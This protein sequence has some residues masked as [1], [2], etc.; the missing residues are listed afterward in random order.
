MLKDLVKLAD[1][2]DSTQQKALADQVDQYISKFAGDPTIAPY[3]RRS[4]LGDTTGEWMMMDEMM[5]TEEI[6][7]EDMIAQHKPTPEIIEAVQK[8]L[9]RQDQKLHSIKW[10][11]PGVGPGTEK[12]ELAGD[13][14][15]WSVLARPMKA[16]E[17][18]TNN[19]W[20][21]WE[22]HPGDP[23]WDSGYSVMIPGKGTKIYGEW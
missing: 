16:E 5:N 11:Q 21:F 7:P 4:D 12:R 22:V 14:P 15:Y 19:H 10:H 13:L 17:V 20:A 23:E 6:P 9:S 18:P 2:L 1:Y 8:F 3:V